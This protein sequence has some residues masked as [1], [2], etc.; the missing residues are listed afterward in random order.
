MEK[1][2]ECINKSAKAT[3]ASNI[4]ELPAAA[5]GGRRVQTV[6]FQLQCS[7]WQNTQSHKCPQ[8]NGW[9]DRM[10]VYITTGWVV[11][12]SKQT[13]A[14]FICLFNLENKSFTNLCA[15]DANVI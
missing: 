11:V 5:A 8:N 10:S 14:Q 15:G 9:T 12:K 7:I 2:R 3:L 1:Q 4:P 6:S 13:R